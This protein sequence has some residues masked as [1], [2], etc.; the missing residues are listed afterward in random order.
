MINREQ[1]G[2]FIDANTDNMVKDWKRLVEIETGSFDKEGLEEAAGTLKAMFEGIGFRC[3][4]IDTGAAGKTLTGILGRE[5]EGKPILFSGHYDTVFPKGTL[6]DNPFRIEN[7]RAYGPG[8]L[9]MKGGIIIAYYV[10]K[11][12]NSLG[13][14]ERPI[15][16]L[17]AGDEEIAHE[18]S[19]T[20]ETLVEE[21]K[22][23]EFAFNMET[24]LPDGSLC[25]G[26]KGG[27]TIS[28]EV[29][30]VEAH[31]G[32]SFETGRN[33]IEEM[34]YKIC[35]LREITNLSEGL[36]VSV[37]TIK[38]GTVSNSI[39]GSCR[40]EIDARFI[41]PSQ[42]E[43]LEHDLYAA[44]DETHIP[45]TQTTYKVLSI[46]NAFE[47][48]NSVKKL[49][50]F[51]SQAL[52]DCGEEP[53]K[54]TVLGGNS[55]AAYIN[56]AGTPVICSCGVIGQG[57]HTGKEFAIVAT[58]AERAKMLLSILSRLDSYKGEAE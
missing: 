45:G 40:I 11:A 37:G 55:D 8:V 27:I 41:K 42:M 2:Q 17:F 4:L 20:A 23:C 49:F 31:A 34:A 35:R 25:V 58:M 22:N 21:A 26:R 15:K 6:A 10:I 18:N 54:S 9:D 32:N 48:T 38:G 44:L 43:K 52:Q 28:A 7:G 36:T 3:D 47:T 56:I 24:G 1:C 46:I 16:I 50:D 30:G 12:L 51:C 13:F 53:L 57:N 29:T 5:R 33:A 14:T 19:T 39:P